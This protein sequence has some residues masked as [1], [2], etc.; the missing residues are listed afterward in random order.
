MTAIVHSLTS[1]R[2][3]RFVT[4]GVGAG[5]LFFVLSFLLVSA[6]MPPF[7]GSLL[8]FAIAFVFAYAAQHS[9]TFESRH[10]HR[11]SLPR[12]LTL[13]VACALF[14]AIVAHVAVRYFGMSPL[15]MSATTTLLGGAVSYVV[16]SLWVFPDKDG[17]E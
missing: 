3:F 5:L 6:G 2:L 7:P 15:A 14:S 13:Q 9:W 1:M 8:A 17:A 4:V 16:S 12:Y 10:G 11:R